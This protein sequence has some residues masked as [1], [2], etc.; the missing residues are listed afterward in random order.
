MRTALLI[1]LLASLSFAGPKLAPH[2]PTDA[3]ATV[4]RDHPVF[5]PRRRK[6]NSSRWA[7]TADEEGFQNINEANL[8]L[9][10]S[11]IQALES[12]PNVAYISPNRT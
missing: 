9:P 5:Q 7:R 6:K 10:I 3:N 4:R 1:A 12:D 8:Q 2:L 11:L